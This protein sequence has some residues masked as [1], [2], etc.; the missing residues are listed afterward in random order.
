MLISF[1]DGDFNSFICIYPEMEV[2]HETVDLF[3]IFWRMSIPYF[4]VP[5]NPFASFTS[6]RT[7]S[8]A[9]RASWFWM[10]IRQNCPLS[11]LDRWGHALRLAWF[12]SSHSDVG[13]WTV[14]SWAS[15]EG[16]GCLEQP[17]GPS[18]WRHSP[19]YLSKSSVCT[20]LSQLKMWVV[21]FY[22][23]LFAL[24]CILWIEVFH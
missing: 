18:W 11:S 7:D 20:F 23:G 2:L 5:R 16:E 14:A 1:W 6:I 24:L 3:L 8:V 19:R 12:W 4:L 22:Y 17:M 15:C 9:D 21:I 13:L 10:R